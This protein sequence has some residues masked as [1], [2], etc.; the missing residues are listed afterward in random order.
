MSDNDEASASIPGSEA[1]EP[2]QFTDWPTSM[3]E[4]PF[5][6]IGFPK[7]RYPA[8]CAVYTIGNGKARR[9]IWTLSDQV[10]MH[11]K[12]PEE[13]EQHKSWNSHMDFNSTEE[14]LPTRVFGSEGHEEDHP[15]TYSPPAHPPS[16]HPPSKLIWTWDLQRYRIPKDWMPERQAKVPLPAQ[17]KKED[18][19][20]SGTRTS[21]GLGGNGIE[22]T[23]L[24]S[25]ID[26]KPIDTGL[27]HGKGDL[28]MQETTSCPDTATRIDDVEPKT[29]KA[30]SPASEAIM[31]IEAVDTGLP[32]NEDDA[33]N[34]LMARSS[35][36]VIHKT[37]ETTSLSPR[38]MVKKPCSR[39]WTP[40]R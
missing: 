23:V 2:T 15:A 40:K 38:P 14:R 36:S 17:T 31:N 32:D 28:K 16:A 10:S 5:V 4:R 33:P 9:G 3:P 22:M 35:L 21:K 29:S 12:E 34:I 1:E 37:N 7:K 20:K 8:R 27:T 26:S 39:Y 25:N 24:D 30:A 19:D 6:M 13:W 18:K 11:M